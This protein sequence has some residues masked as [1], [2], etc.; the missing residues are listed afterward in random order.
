M[1]FI[2]GYM[3]NEVGCGAA[4]RNG[5]TP[6]C[7]RSSSNWI[8]FQVSLSSFDAHS[9]WSSARCEKNR[10]SRHP[11]PLCSQVHVHIDIAGSRYRDERVHS[12]HV[13]FGSDEA[14][15][16]GGCGVGRIPEDGA[17]RSSAS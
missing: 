5:S 3:N 1:E 14:I 8:R 15:L 6:S 10:Q 7:S 9:K 4:K 11:P 16:Y 13:L 2:D 17:P 12:S